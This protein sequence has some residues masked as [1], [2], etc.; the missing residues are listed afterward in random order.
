MLANDDLPWLWGSGASTAEGDCGLR[1]PLGGQLE[2]VKSGVVGD[3]RRD[4]DDDDARIRT[5][6][7]MKAIEKRLKRLSGEVTTHLW[8]HFS[9]RPMPYGISGAAIFTRAAASLTGSSP[10]A[11]EELRAKLRTMNGRD[12]R[13]VGLENQTNELVNEAVN[14]YDGL[15]EPPQESKAQRQH[16]RAFYKLRN[17][18]A[19]TAGMSEHSRRFAGS[20]ED[21]V[22]ELDEQ[23]ALDRRIAKLD[24]L[25]EAMR[26]LDELNLD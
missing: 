4:A 16:D 12:D 10:P 20:P 17:E 26:G 14:A 6:T 3:F 22:D 9:Q 11:P 5:A 24:A 19:A 21:V 13:V 2:R 25:L 8:A 7:R 15:I 1:S 18:Y 23:S